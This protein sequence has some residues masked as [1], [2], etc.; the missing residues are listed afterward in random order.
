MTHSVAIVA[1]VQMNG[2]AVA[3]RFCGLSL[4]LLLIELL[5]GLDL[6]F[7]LHSPILEP[8]LDL[9][10][11]EAKL[12]SHFD[13]ASPREVVI[14]V[15]LLLKLQ[16]LVTGVSLTASSPEAIGPGE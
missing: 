14:R 7:E 3:Y 4:F 13:P 5:D 10:L 11:G 9:S 15:E 1:S 8:D 6:L 12:V 2:M 16:C